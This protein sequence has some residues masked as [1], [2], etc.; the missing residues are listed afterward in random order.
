MTTAPRI[1]VKCAASFSAQQMRAPAATRA[2]VEGVPAR[3]GLS[4][5]R[6]PEFTQTVSVRCATHLGGCV[7]PRSLISYLMPN[8]FLHV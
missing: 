5:F 1:H 7:F 6:T 2:P 8:L 3:S 4:A